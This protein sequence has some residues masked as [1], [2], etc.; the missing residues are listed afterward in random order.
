MEK[1]KDEEFTNVIRESEI[2]V[3]VDFNAEWCMPCK[4][5]GRVL[6]DV[7][8]EYESKVRFVSCDVEECP[9]TAADYTV[10]NIPTVIIFK[11]GVLAERF[12]GACAK[13][14]IIEKIEKVLNEQI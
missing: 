12:V 6:E 5:L 13:K 1:I 9:E 14:R 11:N 7:A 8:A 3:L 2:P 10:S 4:T